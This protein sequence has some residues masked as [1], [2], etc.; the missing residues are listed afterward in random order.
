[1]EEF[2]C[3]ELMCI[4]E[5]PPSR[6]T[7]QNEEF[8]WNNVLHVPTMT[9]DNLTTRSDVLDDLKTLSNVPSDVSFRLVDLTSPEVVQFRNKIRP[10]SIPSPVFFTSRSAVLCANS[11]P[12]CISRNQTDT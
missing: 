9:E 2:I 5:P 4:P 1:M 6:R 10:Q 12:V 7:A 11:G 3:E 8:Y